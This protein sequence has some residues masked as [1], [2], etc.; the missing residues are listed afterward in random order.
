MTGVQTC[1]LPISWLAAHNPEIDWE[2]EKV[3]MTRCPPICKKEKQ[4]E[5]KKEV[6]KIEKDEDKEILRKLV[7]KRF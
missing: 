6:K 5:K 1:A 4:E 3:K 7:P 2:K